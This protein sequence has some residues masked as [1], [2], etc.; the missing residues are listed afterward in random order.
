MRLGM[1]QSRSGDID[2]IILVRVP[3]SHGM[4]WMLADGSSARNDL[5]ARADGLLAGHIDGI[6]THFA[7][8]NSDKRL[9]LESRQTPLC[10]SACPHH[11]AHCGDVEEWNSFMF[12]RDRSYIC[13]TSAD[14]VKSGVH[15]ENGMGGKKINILQ[16]DV[17]VSATPGTI[18]RKG[19]LHI[20]ERDR[21]YGVMDLRQGLNAVRAYIE[22]GIQGPSERTSKTSARTPAKEIVWTEVP[23]RF[24]TATGW[25]HS[26]IQ[27]NHSCRA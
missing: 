15:G 24:D 9:Y 12:L 1:F 2:P 13:N 26:V 20:S 11:T 8:T 23:Y 3:Y 5:E 22:Q 10:D 21:L 18:D 14:I 17:S 25:N 7:V 16:E 6:C 4:C 19:K 27:L